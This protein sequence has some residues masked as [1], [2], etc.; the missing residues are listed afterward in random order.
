M[1][2][3]KHLLDSHPHRLDVDDRATTMD[4]DHS[5]KCILPVIDLASLQY[6]STEQCRASIVRTASEWGAGGRVPAALR[7]Q[8]DKTRLVIEEVSTAMSKLA[9]ILVVDLRGGGDDEEEEDMVVRCTWNMCFLRLN[10]YPPCGAFELCP[11]SDSDFLTILHQ[12]D[13]VGGLQLLKAGQWLAAWSNE[14]YRNV[15]HR[16]MASM[17]HERF[18]VAFFLCPAIDTLIRPCCS[19]GGGGP[20]CKSFTFGE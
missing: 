18:S 4:E 2:P 5:S 12:A 8:G 10:W 11:H 1:D 7:A 6:A 14:R 16:V 19:N 20:R 9:G 3:Y 17:A 13:G 15:E